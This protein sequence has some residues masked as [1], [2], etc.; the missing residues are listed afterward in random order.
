MSSTTI[1]YDNVACGETALNVNTGGYD[2]SAFGFGAVSSNTYGVGNLNF[3]DDMRY[4]FELNLVVTTC[5]W[6]CC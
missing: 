5:C 1:G 6:I 3:G 2:N 4:Y